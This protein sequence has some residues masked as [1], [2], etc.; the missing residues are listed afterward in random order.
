MLEAETWLTARQV[1]ELFTNVIVTPANRA[2]A[3]VPSQGIVAQLNK[4]P[5]NVE[6]VD[7]IT[8][9]IVAQKGDEPMT[10]E[11]LKKAI[12]DGSIKA[13]EVKALVL[14]SGEVVAK[15]DTIQV[16]EALGEYKTVQA[17]QELLAKAEQGN[18]YMTDLIEQAKSARVKAQGD[19]FTEE[20]ANRYVAMLARSNDIEFVKDEIATFEAQALKQL[21]GGRQIEDDP[22]AK[23]EE[24]VI[25]SVL[26]KKGE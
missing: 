13:D 12:A 2:V 6:V 15:A 24:D 7:E 9:P 4:L 26:S 19:D 8:E 1:E 10:L 16:I 18:A 20:Q 14:Q 5:D 21:Q 25:K 22:Q 17:V 3:Q 11:E 23:D